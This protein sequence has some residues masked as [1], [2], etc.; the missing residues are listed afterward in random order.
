[1]WI[2]IR[3]KRGNHQYRQIEITRWSAQLPLLLI[4]LLT[5]SLLQIYI[6]IFLSFHI[7]FIIYK[8]ILFFIMI[9]PIWK[10]LTV[11][12]ILSFSFNQN[13]NLVYWITLKWCSSIIVVQG[14]IVL[15]CTLLTCIYWNNQLFVNVNVVYYAS[16]S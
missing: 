4:F 10:I 1:M 11:L 7:N 15:W 13:Y 3:Q 9:N 2:I 12:Q 16:R 8:S 6:D 5:V 14:S